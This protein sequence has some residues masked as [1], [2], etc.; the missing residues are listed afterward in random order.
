[1]QHPALLAAFLLLDG[2]VREQS[3]MA[4]R[5]GT[6][7]LRRSMAFRDGTARLRSS[8]AQLAGISRRYSSTVYEDTEMPL[9]AVAPV[10]E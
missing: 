4:F 5:D 6:V 8:I 9:D 10:C 2:T 1:M 3:S 7:R